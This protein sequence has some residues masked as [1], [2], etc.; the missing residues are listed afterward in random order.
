M[1]DEYEKEYIEYIQIWDYSPLTSYLLY[2][3]EIIPIPKDFSTAI[4]QL[5]S[6]FA[7]TIISAKE[8]ERLS[9][10]PYYSNKPYFCKLTFSSRK[11]VGDNVKFVFDKYSDIF[12]RLYPQFRETLIEYWNKDSDSYIILT[13]NS[14][15]SSTTDLN[16]LFPLNILYRTIAGDIGYGIEPIFSEAQSYAE[17]LIELGFI[18]SNNEIER[19]GYEFNS[20]DPLATTI[21]FSTDPEE[22]IELKE[23]KNQVFLMDDS[24][25]MTSEQ[26][27][28]R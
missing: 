13:K 25:Y 15:N 28:L 26:I 1:I 5:F 6:H 22:N 7:I 27:E 18:I 14:E 21:L 3:G 12:G 11:I 8:I 19:S 17:S 10:E 23:T 9:R 4:L 16:I 2:M 24:K 20:E